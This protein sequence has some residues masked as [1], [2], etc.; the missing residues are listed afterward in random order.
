MGAAYGV[1]W[2]GAEPADLWLSVDGGASYDLVAAGVGGAESNFHSAAMDGIAVRFRDTIG[3]SETAP[4]VLI[5][6]EQ[7]V[8][9]NTGNLLPEGF[10]AVVMIEDVH[11]LEDGRVE[12]M[13]AVPPWQH[14]RTIGED[15]VVTELILPTGQKIR[16]IDQ[17]AMLA[18][19]VQ[20]V[21]VVIF[22]ITS[23][24]GSYPFRN[25]NL[26]IFSS[27]NLILQKLTHI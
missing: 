7:F 10:D 12:I 25:F 14:V 13:S 11:P 21:R 26:F 23:H 4:L 2:L 15:I 16:P 1:S 6:N 8:Y 9:V 19:G 3:A 17:G 27:R 5:E 24:F 22:W 20:K 18:T